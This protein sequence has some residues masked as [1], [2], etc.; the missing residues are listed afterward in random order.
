M[1]IYFSSWLIELSH[2]DSH[3]LNALGCSRDCACSRERQSGDG[4]QRSLSPRE[5]HKISGKSLEDFCG[6]N[7]LCQIAEG[8]RSPT[9]A[10]E[11]PQ[12]HFVF[13]KWSKRLTAAISKSLDL[14]LRLLPPY[15]LWRSRAG[16]LH[17]FATTIKKKRNVYV[18]AGEWPSTPC[19]LLAANRVAVPLLAATE[20]TINLHMNFAYPDIVT[21]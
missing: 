8:C 13:G 21:A 6:Q 4:M 19:V 10:D 11:M 12:R 20:F 15:R 14:F 3:T 17:N 1:D 9:S 7:R 16:H 5:P 2:G 18:A